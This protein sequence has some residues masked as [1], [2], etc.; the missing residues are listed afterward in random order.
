MKLLMTTLLTVLL[1]GPAFAELDPGKPADAM[2]ISRKVGCST[3][4]GQATT[5]SW[6]GKLYA[7][8]M[9]ERDKHLFDIEGMNVRACSSVSDAKRGDGYKMVSREIMLYL[10][11]KTGE[12]LNRWEN[13]FTGEEVLVMHVAN[14]PVNFAQ[15]EKGR[16][17]SPARWPGV[18]EGDLYRQ[19][20]TV[21]L[22]Y[23]N[24]LAGEFQKE[25]GGVYHATEM[26]NFFGDASD[27]L[28]A[29]QD[30]A[31][32]HVGW[33]RISGW[34]PWMNMGG[35][36]GGIYVH[37]AGRKLDSWNDLSERMK[38]EI[39][40][41]YPDYVAPPPLDDARK[42][43]TS[44]MYYKRVRDGERTLPDRD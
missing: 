26:F 8:R 12:V 33:V 30:I 13:P 20:T 15:Y 27:L 1:S 21:P 36:E 23:P 9:G 43:E 35:R 32:P 6:Y 7:R 29:D 34:L 28:D 37:A 3:V 10:D 41:H 24:P 22:F 39:R 18:I 31:Y 42:N 44:W 40:N 4:D 38:G 19:T 14:D 25:I 11:P 2:T 16:D 17:G 5:Y